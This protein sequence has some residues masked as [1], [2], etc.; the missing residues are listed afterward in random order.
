MLRVDAV[1]F[2]AQLLVIRAPPG[3]EPL[4]HFGVGHALAV[5]IDR[6]AVEG[7]RRAQARGGLAGIETG[8]VGRPVQVDD[9]ARMRGL[10]HRGAQLAGK[11]VQPVEVP[12]GVGHA[13]GF[14]GQALGDRRRNVRAH[15]RNGQ[16]QGLRALVEQEGGRCI[17]HD[18][19]SFDQSSVGVG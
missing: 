18:G 6:R 16:Q 3:F 10:Q 17:R 11:V 8:V 5:A 19:F 15:V 12:V 9:V 1:E 4:R 7:L 2:A 13:P 14:V